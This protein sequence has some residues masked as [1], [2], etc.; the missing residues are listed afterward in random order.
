MSKK[1]KVGVFPLRNIIL[2]PHTVLPLI[3][4]D[5]GYQRMLKDSIE[6]NFPIAVGL[7][8]TILLGDPSRPSPY[9]RPRETLGL[10]LANILETYEDGSQYVIFQGIGKIRLE[11]IVHQEPYLLCHGEVIYDQEP[12]QV[13][14][15]NNPIKRLESLLFTWLRHN[16]D[17]Y[18]H[19]NSMLTTIKTANQIVD[20]ICAF[21]VQD[22][23]LKQILLE[24]RSLS[25]RIALLDALLPKNYH[26][27]ESPYVGELIKAYEFDN[28]ATG[29]DN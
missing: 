8:D 21:L 26:N 29:T 3:I 9:L 25:E 10:G 13:A 20:Y 16:V 23:D 15:L 11:G 14:L 17:D 7:G 2:Y 24:S 5:E 1:I 18:D 12:S 27:R 22:N 28:R 19:L 6:Q 4:N